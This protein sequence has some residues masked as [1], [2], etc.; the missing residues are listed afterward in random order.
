MSNKINWYDDVI[1]LH[2]KTMLVEEEKKER[3]KEQKHAD[4]G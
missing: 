2:D 3:G 4:M 1:F